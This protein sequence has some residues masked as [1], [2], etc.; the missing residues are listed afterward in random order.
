LVDAEK[1]WAD[2]FKLLTAQDR[3]DIN[4]IIK[5]AEPRRN[6][7]KFNTGSISVTTAQALRALTK[8]ITPDTIIEVGTF[9]GVS[10]LSMRANEIYTCD[11]SN[12]CLP[13]S[14]YNTVNVRVH[15][16]MESTKMLRRLAASG[17]RAGMFFFDG[18]LAK[19]DPPLVL[20]LSKPKALYVFDDYEGEYKGVQ[21]ARKLQPLLPHHV[22]IERAG[23]IAQDT[24]LAALVHTSLI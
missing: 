5:E 22:L 14:M 4:Q 7:A 8:W 24:T 13:S 2:R 9:I 1:F 12:D 18:L 15:P 16:K 17:D 20:E 6:V 23:P 21:N 11:W 3:A 10:T 19:E